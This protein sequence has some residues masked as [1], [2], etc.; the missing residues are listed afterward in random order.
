[1]EQFLI[2]IFVVLKYSEVPAPLFKILRTLL[3][4]PN[5]IAQDLS[6][7]ENWNHL[8]FKS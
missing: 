7:L 1:M 5:K 2:L 8:Q 4:N 3:V 6:T